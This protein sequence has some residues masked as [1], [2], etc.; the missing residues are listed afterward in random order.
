MELN[1]I[2]EPS[3]KGKHLKKE[4]RVL[5]ELM[6][7]KGEPTK[8]IADT[9][10]RSVRTIQREIVRGKVIHLDTYLREKK[11]Y[12]SDR[13]QDIYDLNAS[14]KGPQL[15]LGKNWNIVEF[16]RFCIVDHKD[17]PDVIAHRM[18]KEGMEGSIC[19]K[20]IY[21]Y[22]D[23][24]LISGV[25]NESL[26]EKRKRR[27]R[28]RRTIRRVRKIHTRRLSIE[29]RPKHIEDR[30]EFGHWEIDLVVGPLGSKASVLTLNERK[31]RRV[32]VRKLKN[33]TNDAVQRALN[34]IERELGPA[35]FTRTFKSITADNGS[36]FL[37]VDKLQ[38]S[39]RS[40]KL[41]TCV[42]YAHPY[43]SWE[44]GSNENVNRMIRRFIS[45]GARIEKIS[46][47][48][49]KTI[50]EWINNYPRRIIGYNTSQEQFEKEV[51]DLI[52]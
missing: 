23:L 39:I 8:T 17:S 24:N 4:E 1:E 33:K 47:A 49:I 15:K 31:T 52:A 51:R 46:R 9:L 12:S 48:A 6:L 30:N 16:I 35:N 2:I 41:R 44:R 50:E 37:N 40:G 42:F 13:G 5:I 27:R 28:A 22:V 10:D 7:R 18:R 34:G 45:K 25:T 21:N 29:K 19:T 38:G 36:E 20:T 26:W 14:A 3:K 11:V 43:S 32:I